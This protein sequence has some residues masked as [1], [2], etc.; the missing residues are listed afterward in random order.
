MKKLHLVHILIPPMLLA[1]FGAAA[2][3]SDVSAVLGP[4]PM[5]EAISEA[6]AEGLAPK[7]DCVVA[8]AGEAEGITGSGG[9]RASCTADCGS[10]A[11]DVSCS[12][13]G[14]CTAI[15]RNC[16]AGQRGQVTCGSLTRYCP[17]C[18]CTEGQIRWEPRSSC[19]CDYT[20]DWAPKNR[21]RL[22]KYRCSN[23]YW[24][25]AGYECSGQNCPGS[26]AL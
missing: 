18:A 3:A 1:F 15:D 12:G 13:S 21:K 26:C 9:L 5:L 20:I 7:A 16:A 4:S 23:G 8:S 24:V 2:H 14:S 25:Y 10:G 17:S 22:D 19:C 6:S 11:S